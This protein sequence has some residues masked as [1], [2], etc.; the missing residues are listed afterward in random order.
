MDPPLPSAA[1]ALILSFLASV[2]WEEVPVSSLPRAMALSN[3]FREAYRSLGAASI[4]VGPGSASLF[5][6]IHNLRDCVQAFRRTVVESPVTLQPRD[7]TLMLGA[8]AAR[9]KPG[10]QQRVVLGRFVFDADDAFWRGGK[11][12]FS[13]L[14]NIGAG[15]GLNL[16]LTRFNKEIS[17]GML[18]HRLGNVRATWRAQCMGAFSDLRLHDTETGRGIAVGC[19]MARLPEHLA[20]PLKESRSISVVIVG[21]VGRG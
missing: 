3:T 6:Y 21:V 2:V 14:L 15:R 7:L 9:L 11:C 1:V 12:V 18:P 20:E 8:M 19:S 17:A 13:S 10:Q 4:Q 5:G 16:M